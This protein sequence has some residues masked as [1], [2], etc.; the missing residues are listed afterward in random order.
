[1]GTF[2]LYLAFDQAFTSFTYLKV[3]PSHLQKFSS[4][5]LLF[6]YYIISHNSMVAYVYYRLMKEHAD[7]QYHTW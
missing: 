7:D 5:I 4:R 6:S 2:R 3:I 1:M